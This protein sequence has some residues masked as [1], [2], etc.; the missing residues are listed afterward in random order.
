MLFKVVSYLAAIIVELVFVLSTNELMLCRVF[1]ALYHVFS[2]T[3]H[4][5]VCRRVEADDS[6]KT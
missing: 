1:S 5:F 3:R 2:T 4:V 6:Y